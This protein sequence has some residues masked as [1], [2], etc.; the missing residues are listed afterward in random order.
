MDNEKYS[1][2]SNLS[3]SAASLWDWVKAICS[4]FLCVVLSLRLYY[5]SVS[6][7]FVAL[8]S[9]LLALFSVALSA[10]FYFKATDTSNK[11]YDNT[12]KYSK[13]VAELLVK[14]ESGF[15]EKLKNL[16]DGYNSMRSMFQSGE[17]GVRV[18]RTKEKIE[19][20][21][22]EIDKVKSERE[23]IIKNLIEKANLQ[24][25]EKEKIS[26]TLAEKERE[27]QKSH[28]EMAK[29]KRILVEDKISDEDIHL[30]S[31]RRLTPLMNFISVRVIPDMIEEIGG[32]ASFKKCSL[33]SIVDLFNKLF[34]SDAMRQSGFIKD[35]IELGYC[36]KNGGLTGKGARLIRKL[37][38]HN[39]D[40]NNFSNG[41]D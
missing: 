11:F 37:A 8:L 32:S 15:G 2:S 18:E 19:S 29:L 30:P 22:N 13:D 20:E 10:M 36:S 6:I 7:D 40:D 39:D 31:N 3:V 4:I 9:T 24:K 33:I 28:N 12:Y 21:R 41:D 38:T 14:I 26:N 34:F 23:A 35:M 5:S 17:H 16:D 25:E 27:L 1:T